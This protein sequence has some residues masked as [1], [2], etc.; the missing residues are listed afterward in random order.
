MAN[1][2]DKNR[3]AWSYQLSHHPQLF[4]LGKDK[5]MG[6]NTLLQPSLMYLVVRSWSKI[7]QSRSKLIKDLDGDADRVK[8]SWAF[9]IDTWTIIRTSMKEQ[10]DARGKEKEREWGRKV[11]SINIY[12]F[13]SVRGISRITLPTAHVIIHIYIMFFGFI[14]FVISPVYPAVL[15]TAQILKVFLIIYIKRFIQ[16]SHQALVCSFI[17]TLKPSNTTLTQ[18]LLKHYWNV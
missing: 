15:L 4:H 6:V 9:F 3:V 1:Q 5:S 8:G 12:G 13:G 18:L 10:Q 14:I 16:W 2:W 7:T 17:P 11:K